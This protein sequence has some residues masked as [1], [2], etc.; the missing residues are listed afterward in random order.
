MDLANILSYFSGR[1]ETINN[2]LLESLLIFAVFILLAKLIDYIVDKI[3]K[4]EL[5]S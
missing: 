3:L 2:P 4:N 5:A 1:L